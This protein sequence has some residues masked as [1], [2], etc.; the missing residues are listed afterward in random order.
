MKRCPQCN[1]TYTDDALSFCLDDGS[2]LTV[3]SGPPPDPS[4]TLQYPQARDTTPQPTI[5]YNPG[6]AAPPP[7]PPAWSPMPPPQTQKRSVWPWLLGIGAV[8]L[9]MG[10]GVVVLIVMV[11]R[12]TNDNNGNR[13]ANN[14]NNSNNA[15]WKSANRNKNT[16]SDNTNE[17]TNTSSTPSSFTDDFSKENWGTGTWD[18]GRAWYSD[19]EYHMHAI[20]G[21]FIEMY[22]PDKKEYN[23][24][25]A[26]VRVGLRSIDGNPP[27]TGYGLVVHGEKKDN[28]L[29]DY[30][31]LIYNGPGPK[32]KIILHKAGVETNIVS[33]TSSNVI[34]T[35]TSPNQIEVRISGLKLDLYI[36]G[37]FITS[38]TDSAGY[39]RGRVGF[40]TSDAGEVAFDDLE[41]IR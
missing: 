20:N 18:D 6:Q 33:W 41:I 3:A 38:I 14:S 16:N 34:R 32:Y 7:P 13:V 31:F 10:I 8:L 9:L 22:G 26:T 2:P 27:N 11:A 5:A 25:N 12:V 35:G 36:N 17:N 30:G 1:R 15:N 19:E 4:A 21:R 23:T 29:E 40:Y 28:K 39:H 24:E 37:Q